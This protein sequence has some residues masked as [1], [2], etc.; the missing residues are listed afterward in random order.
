MKCACVAVVAEGK[1]STHVI[2]AG[3]VY[4]VVLEKVVV[5]SNPEEGALRL[6]LPHVG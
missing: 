1:E 2:V 4:D 3:T 6:V 5:P